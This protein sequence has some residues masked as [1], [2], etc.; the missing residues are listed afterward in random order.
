MRMTPYESQT[1]NVHTLVLYIEATSA[2]IRVLVTDTVAGR[3]TED[4]LSHWTD[5]NKHRWLRLMER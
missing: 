1:T 3:R 4:G 5:K 2:M